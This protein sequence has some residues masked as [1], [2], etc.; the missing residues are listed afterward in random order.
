MKK[1][2][3]NPV[4]GTRDILPAAAQLRDFALHKILGAYQACGFRR[5]E[6]PVLE[7]LDLLLAGQGGENEKLIFKVMKRG[8]K[9]DVANAQEESDIAEY[10][11]RFDLTI[12]LSRFYANNISQLP[13]PFKS[14]Q[15]GPVW[16]AERPQ[17]GRYRQFVQC[18]IDVIGEPS[19][20]A[21]IDLIRT[22]ARC[23]N[24][25]G[26]RDF[27]IRINNRQ[28]IEALLVECG[29]APGDFASIMIALDKQDKIGIEGVQAELNGYPAVAV[30]RLIDFLNEKIDTPQGMTSVFK[31]TP[32]ENVIGLIDELNVVMDTVRA[33]SKG[34]FQILFDPSLIRGMGYYTGQIFEISYKDFPFS[35]AGGGRYDGVIGRLM[36][37]DVAACGFSIGFERL[38]EVLEAEN[39]NGGEGETRAIVFVDDNAQSLAAYGFAAQAAQQYAVV[40][41]LR[42]QKNHRRQLEGLHAEGYAAFYYYTGAAY[43][44][45]S[46]EF[47]KV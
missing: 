46:V 14:I 33:L 4:R 3:V 32:P 8:E 45:R 31:G 37:R 47:E 13:T 39:L 29:F 20:N 12:P 2:N 7:S 5:I 15:A 11:M 21:E 28:L 18:D 36:G 23:L 27:I 22:T 35:I 9:L 6:T 26:L 30:Q 41:V 43:Q 10:G 44:K 24:G 25:V 34:D 17:R 40:N 16:R 1:V 38:C 19:I 42:K